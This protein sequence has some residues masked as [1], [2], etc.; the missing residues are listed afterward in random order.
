[1]SIPDFN[2]QGLLPPYNGEREDMHQA[3]PYPAT[4]LELCQK[5]G[6]TPQRREILHGYLKF[7]SLLH[8]LQ[9]VEGFQWVDGRFLEQD[10]PKG[11]GPEY[12][13]VVTFCKDSPLFEDPTFD[14]ISAPLTAPLEDIRKQFRVDPLLVSLDWPLQD[15]ISHTRHYSGLLSHQQ[16][17]GVWK[18]M[19]EIKLHTLKEDAKAM[20]HLNQFERP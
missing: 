3:S 2:N 11:D 10:T 7:R 13:Q 8:Q 19:L 17:T 6:S 16:E 9:V 12:I 5:F 15:V 14:E 18:G 1:M 20:D 4:T